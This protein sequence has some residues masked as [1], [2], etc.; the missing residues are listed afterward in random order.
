MKPVISQQLSDIE[1]QKTFR[2]MANRPTRVM[3]SAPV[4]CA[5]NPAAKRLTTEE[6]PKIEKLNAV[7]SLWT[8]V[9]A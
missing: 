2:P 5:T 3:F 1:I 4:R 6:I 9:L 8:C 7:S